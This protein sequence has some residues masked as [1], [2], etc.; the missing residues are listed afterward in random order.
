MAD[1]NVVDELVVK[2]SLDAS[3]YQKSEKKID[4]IVDKTEK[5]Q[6]DLDRKKK[7][8]DQ[9]NTKRTKET[10]AAVKQL[11]EGF[12]KLAFTVGAVLGIGGGASGILGAI[13]ALAGMETGLRRATVS[14]GMSNR[15]LQAW[16]STARRLGTDAQAGQAAIAALAKEQ[17]Q[18][19]LTG[20]G[21]TMSA[22]SRMGVNVGPNVSIQDI[23]AQAQ[24]VYHQAAPA[25]QKQYEAQLSASGVSD[26]LI[27]MIKSEKDVREQYAKSYAESAEENRK[28]LDAVSD[29]LATLENSSISVANTL[30]TLLGPAIQS[31]AD[32]ATTGAQDLSAFV[33][34]VIAAGGGVDGFMQVLHQ[35]S[36]QLATLLDD[37]GSAL[38]VMGQAVDV[39]VFGF[40]ELADAGGALFDWIDGALS[41]LG[42]GGAGGHPLTQAVQTVGAAVK[43]AWTDMVGEARSSGAAPVGALTGDTGNVALTP[44]ARARIAAGALGDPSLDPGETVVSPAPARSARV[45]GSTQDQANQLMTQL[46]ANGLTP[47]EAAAVAGNAFRESTLGRNNDNSAG[48]GN[49]AHG[50]LQWRGDRLKRFQAR[51][52]MSPSDAPISTQIDFMMT[53]PYER[54][55]LDKSFAGGGS[56]A[57]LGQRFS[58]IYEVTGSSAE[59]NMRGTYAGQ[60]AAGYAA[61]GNPV[62]PEGAGGAPAITIS[63]PVTVTANDP[64]Q[65]VDGITRI[66]P[67]QSYNSANR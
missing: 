18:F 40:K 48:G 31:F 14:T 66:S 54:R 49:G 16:G 38:S 7:K 63:G 13:T 64:R 24:Q 37:V 44:S 15:E 26:D 11:S 29:A 19:N 21:A 5:K 23:L 56:A 12:G 33:D 25:Q 67:I 58:K 55:L 51:Y 43:W 9:D 34:K 50:L 47:A 27:V 57:E 28:A 53:D 8:R 17:Q 30:A 20:N 46:V 22:F 35:Q 45:T 59:D 6:V 1:A 42:I 36:P 10:T 60:F 2:L 4:Q 61:G 3:D 62:T 52:G 65:L 32:W 41:K 39:V